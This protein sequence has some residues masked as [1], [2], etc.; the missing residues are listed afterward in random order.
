MSFFNDSREIQRY[1]NDVVGLDIQVD[2]LGKNDLQDLPLYIRDSYRIYKTRL[3]ER[4]LLLLQPREK[5]GK[6]VYPPLVF[7][8]SPSDDYL[9]KA[10]GG[11]TSTRGPLDWGKILSL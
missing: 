6:T 2:L 11:M 9:A 4:P 1:F 7:F 5:D 10:T 8:D 3:F